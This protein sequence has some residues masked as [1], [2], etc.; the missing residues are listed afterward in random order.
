MTCAIQSLDLLRLEESVAAPILE[1]EGIAL[2]AA[3]SLICLRSLYLEAQ[4]KGA[5][6]RFYPCMMTENDYVLGNSEKIKAMLEM[7][8]AAEDI[9]GIV[10]YVSCLEVIS[11]MDLE[12]VLRKAD[13]P[14]GKPVRILQRGPMV[15]RRKKPREERDSILKE[16]LSYPTISDNGSSEKMSPTGGEIMPVM[17]PDIAA[18]F[19]MLQT[20]PVDQL[21]ITPGGCGRCLDLSTEIHKSHGMYRTSFNDLDVCSGFSSHLQQLLNENFPSE[22]M[23]C[24]LF[25]SVTKMSGIEQTLFLRHNQREIFYTDGFHYGVKAAAEALKIMGERFAEK[26]RLQPGGHTILILGHY[27]LGTACRQYYT[28]AVEQIKKQGFDCVHLFQLWELDTLPE[29]CSLW[30]WNLEG[31]CLAE[32]WCQKW[33]IPIYQELHPVSEE[34]FPEIKKGAKMLIMTEALLGSRLKKYYEKQGISV[35]LGLYAPDMKTKEFYET[36]L[37]E[38]IF[39]FSEL[40]EL[41]RLIGDKDVVLADRV[42]SEYVCDKRCV[43]F[44]ITYPMIGGSLL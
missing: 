33:H 36:F 28:R 41:E 40:H 8:A 29:I 15:K 37:K 3:G 30:P 22:K 42:F 18:V 39:Y 4:R 19:S 35:E 6:K 20:F 17:A 38:E 26:H 12:E 25:G 7:A 13:N 27:P 9:R 5:L 16:L 14:K 2:V 32:T 1:T 24:C 34:V 21:L 11:G 43:F 10:F 23:L 44:E 31:S